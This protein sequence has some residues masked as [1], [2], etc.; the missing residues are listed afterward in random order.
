MTRVVQLSSF[1]AH[2]NFGTGPILGSHFAEENIKRVPNIDLTILRATYFY[3]NLFNYI[4]MI[5][6]TG[7][8]TANY[9]STKSL[10]ALSVRIF[11]ILS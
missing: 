10:S 3:Y 9:G 1:G 6:Y 4:D 7:K 11:G 5:K 8:I 2:L